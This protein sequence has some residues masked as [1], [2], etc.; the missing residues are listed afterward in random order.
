M[1]FI[2]TKRRILK[3]DAIPS[4]HLFNKAINSNM[5]NNSNIMSYASVSNNEAM[6]NTA[7]DPNSIPILKS[8]K[9]KEKEETITELKKDVRRLKK[10]IYKKKKLIQ[11]QKKEKK[12]LRRGNK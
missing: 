1:I 11:Q 4:M 5:N 2:D 8:E 7:C 9:Y 6:E 3:N 12:N 10:S